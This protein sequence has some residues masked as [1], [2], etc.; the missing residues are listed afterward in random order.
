VV[1]VVSGQLMGPVFF[2]D[3]AYLDGVAQMG[4]GISRLMITTA[5]HTQTA[6]ETAAS[7]LERRLDEAGTPAT[8]SETQ[9]GM[10]GRLSSELG[11]LVTFLV[12]MGALLALVGVIGLTGTMTINVLESTREIGVMRAIGASHRSIF[13]IFIT[14]GV[15]VGLMAWALGAVASWPI[16]LLL[17][18][19]L[20]GAMGV[21]LTYTFSFAGVG[22]WLVSVLVIAVVASLLPSWRASQVSV[23]DA[24][25]Y[26]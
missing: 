16:S 2:I 4:G 17:T 19:A 22:I 20:S 1:G 9:I 12:I 3:K 8:S 14:E 7:E 18:N 24:I 21:P 23:R 25:A 6:Q 13:G 10:V 15:V 5:S 11:I 26:E